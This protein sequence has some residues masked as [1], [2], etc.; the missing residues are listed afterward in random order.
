M[1][2]VTLTFYGA[3]CGL[4]AYFSHRLNNG[5][6]RFGAGIVVGLVAASALPPLRGWVGL[7]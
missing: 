5:L 6:L 2:P 7:Y 3:V 1:D 4:L